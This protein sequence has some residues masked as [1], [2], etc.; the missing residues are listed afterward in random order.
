MKPFLL[1]VFT[2]SLLFTSTLSAQATFFE[3]ALRYSFVS[4][5]G[6]A[7][8]AGTGGSL[9]PLGVDYTTLHTNPAGLGWNRSSSVQVSPGFT[10]GSLESTFQGNDVTPFSEADVTLML[11]SVGLIIANQTRSVNV[12]TFNVSLGL[13]RL[14][15]Y[16]QTI[17]YDGRS[18]G[19]IAQAILEDE[20]DGVDD[21]FRSNLALQIPGFFQEDSIGLFT[22]FERPESAGGQ[23]RRNGSSTRSGSMHEF[24]IGFSGNYRE[25]LLFGLSLGIP[26]FSYDEDRVYDEIDDR[27]EIIFFDDAGFNETYRYSGTGT[28]LKLGIIYRPTSGTRVS[29]AIHTPTLWSINEEYFSTL[30]YN[31][32]DEGMAQGGTALS[33]RLV[34]VRNLRTPW[35]FLLGGGYVINQKGFISVDFDYTDYTSNNFSTEDFTLQDEVANEQVDLFLSSSIGIRVGGEYNLD[36]IQLR[37]GVGYRQVPFADFAEVEDEAILTYSAGA[38]YNFGRVHVD[39]AAQYEG[40]QTFF[41][42]YNTFAIQDQRVTTDRNRVSLILTVGYRGFNF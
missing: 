19:S 39:L 27:D 3:E 4:P 17:R 42:P 1:G 13:T 18:E 24:A 40:Y 30:E 29:A 31:F 25:K 15:N 32:T 33:P 10:Y 36:P 23:I 21:P 9:T 38:G 34:G 37:A 41:S 7:R 35:R 5:Q 26:F 2:L 8:F 28:N 20:L 16:N 14:A 11:P 6:T 22:D 12:S